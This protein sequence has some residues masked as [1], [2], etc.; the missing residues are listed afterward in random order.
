[1]NNHFHLVLETPELTLSSGMQW[2]ESCYAQRFN[3]R[4]KRIGHLFQGRFKSHLVESESYLLTLV[5]YV[6]LNPV[7]KKY[8]KRPEQWRWSSYRATAGY[9]LAPAWLH[10]RLPARQVLDRAP[11]GAAPLS[12]VRHPRN[13][14][15]VATGECRRPDLS[16]L[17]G[18]HRVDPRE[19]RGEP[20][21]AAIP[22]AQR[23][24]GRPDVAKVIATVASS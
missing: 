9:E 23:E 12:R 18:L 20:R 7:R 21:S 5:R 1:M 3:R 24:A 6:E 15:A 2:F 11:G 17:D 14:R 4:H 22:R 19:D 13:R 10:M 16:R 8:V